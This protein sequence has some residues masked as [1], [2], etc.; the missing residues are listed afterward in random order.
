MQNCKVNS[1]KLENDANT[2]LFDDSAL[3]ILKSAF[4]GKE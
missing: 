1:K 2:S 3:Q 4:V